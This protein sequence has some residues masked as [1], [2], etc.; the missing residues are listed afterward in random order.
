VSCFIEVTE[1]RAISSDTNQWK[2]MKRTKK[3]DKVSG[4]PIGGY[5]DWEA[6]KFYAEF[7]TAATHLESELIRTCGAQTFPELMRAAN[8]IHDMM[9]ELLDRAKVL[10]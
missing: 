8:R 1:K 7:H 9:C 5:S 4:A 6:Y 2:L 10:P 3:T